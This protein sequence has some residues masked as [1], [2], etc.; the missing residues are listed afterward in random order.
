MASLPKF[1]TPNIIMEDNDKF[2]GKYRI[3]STRL[4]GYNYSSNGY[5]FITICTYNREY[6]F[7]DV[8]MDDNHEYSVA[9]THI[10]KIACD[11]WLD[12]PKFHPYVIL[13]EFIIMPNH[14]HGILQ[15]NKINS[16]VETRYV[17]SHKEH[18]SKITQSINKTPGMAS[19]PGDGEYKN[20]FGKQTQNLA[21]IIRGYKSA[22]TIYATKHNLDFH[23]QPRYYDH[24]IRTESSL[25][26]IRQ[27]IKINP[28]KWE[29][30]RNNPVGLNY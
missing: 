14:M 23:W 18:K 9:L 25:N 3:D 15:I 20:T 26:K 11:C 13:D 7:G 29:H 4:P 28:L 21:S 30:D 12:I 6:Y 8:L 17:A 2:I 27:Y 16:P 24:I 10:G 22:V 19:L 1:K 5:Y